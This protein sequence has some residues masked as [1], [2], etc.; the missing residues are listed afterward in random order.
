MAHGN[1]REGKWRGNWRME[2]LA[3]PFPLPRNMVYSA[4]L[5]LMRTP[6]LPV[7]D[8]TDAPA[9]LNGLVRFAERRN[10]VSV[11][12]PSHFKRSLLSMHLV[13]DTGGWRGAG[14]GRKCFGEDSPF[15]DHDSK[16][17][18]LKVNPPL[19][20]NCLACV[21]WKKDSSR[22]LRSLRMRT[23]HCP[24]KLGSSYLPAQRRSP[25]KL[26]PQLHCPVN[27][28]TNS[29]EVYACSPIGVIFNLNNRPEL[30]NKSGN[31]YATRC[32]SVRL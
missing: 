32:L 28:A 1:A 18:I 6:R 2:C 16:T 21:E 27:I 13:G 30:E 20:P 26:D 22:T 11:Y 29:T 14:G 24:V 25:Q 7:V 8:W 12:V 31:T 15:P 4:L 23:A 19:D 9:D 3:T 10:L 17:A 5:P